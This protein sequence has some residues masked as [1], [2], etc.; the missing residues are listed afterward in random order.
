MF[1][2]IEGFEHYGIDRAL[3][4]GLPWLAKWSRSGMSRG[5]STLI[6]PG[7]VRVF[8]C[9]EQLAALDDEERMQ[10]RAVVLSHDNDPIAVLGPD[11][12]MQR[13]AWLA[14]VQRGRG[15]PDEMR[16]L[17]LI[18]FVQTGMD[19]M[20]VLVSEPGEFGSFGH[21]YRADMARFVRDAYDLPSVTEAQLARLEEALRS[22]DLER[23]EHV[24]A[25]RAYAAPAAPTQPS[26]GN[27]LRGGVP[28][29]GRRTRGARWIAR[30]GPDAPV[31][32]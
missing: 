32:W 5:S 23:A 14:D 1:H 9:Y 28:L 7:T 10:L 31:K 3:W 17:P 20:N 22:L 30:R 2:G 24:K 16:W 27:D 18:T 21:D 12:I 26:G 13:P 11:L 19:A 25:K 15:V 6:P 4:V 29:R 8:D